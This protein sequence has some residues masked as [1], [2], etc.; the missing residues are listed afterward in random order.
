MEEAA[1]PCP[2]ARRHHHPSGG[3][4]GTACATTP[5]KA[6]L[7][8]AVGAVRVLDEIRRVSARVAFPMLRQEDAIG[9]LRPAGASFAN[10]VGAKAIIEKPIGASSAEVVHESA[11]ALSVATTGRRGKRAGVRDRSRTLARSRQLRGNEKRRTCGIAGQRFASGGRESRESQPADLP[12]LRAP[13][14][15][16]SYQ[17]VATRANASGGDLRPRSRAARPPSTEA[18]RADPP[19]HSKR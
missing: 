3:P 16:R 14:A 2:R 7:K 11:H 9:M 4:C 19:R 12:V 13:F 18:S 6:S 8:Q 10:V 5:R 17:L 1:S 15:V